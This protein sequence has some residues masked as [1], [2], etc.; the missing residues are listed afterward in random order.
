MLSDKNTIELETLNRMTEQN[1]IHLKFKNLNSLCVKLNYHGYFEVF[2]T[3]QG[4]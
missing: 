3:L 2:R 1:S 4:L